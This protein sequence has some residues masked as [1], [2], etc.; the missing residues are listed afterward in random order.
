MEWILDGRNDCLDG[1]DEGLTWS[2]YCISI[3]LHQGFLTC[4]G[5]INLLSVE[6]GVIGEGLP[7]NLRTSGDITYQKHNIQKFTVYISSRFVSSRT[8][9]RSI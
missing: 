6:T 9:G 1:T 3:W 8:V 5:Y 4:I 7:R 2:V